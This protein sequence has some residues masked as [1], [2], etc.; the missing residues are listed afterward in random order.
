MTDIHDE[1]IA[2]LGEDNLKI[3]SL[4]TSDEKALLKDLFLQMSEQFNVA[5]TLSDPNGQPVFA[6]CGFTELCGRHIRTT[7][8]GS[9]RCKAE[10]AKRGKIGEETQTPQVYKCHAGIFD[11]TAPILLFGRRIGN[12]SGGQ[13]FTRK[14]D[15]GIRDHLSRY[16]DELGV[17]DK[18]AAMAALDKHHVNS[19]EHLEHVAH[20]YF[21]IG[22]L[23][24]HYFQFQVEHNY[25][26]ESILRVNAELE[27]RVAERTSQLQEKVDELKRTQMQMVQQEKLAGIGQL[28]AGVAHEINNPLGFIMGN[29][30][31]LDQY[32]Q[33]FTEALNEYQKFKSTALS[34]NVEEMLPHAE[35]IDKFLAKRKL[36]MVQEDAGDLLEETGE[37]LA[38]IA[39]IVQN[40]K[41]FSQVDKTQ[42]EVDYDFNEGL[43]TTLLMAQNEY[44]DVVDI[45]EEFGNIPAV[46]G[47][48]SE[49]NQVLLN[50]LLN[51]VQAVKDRYPTVE[52]R[53]VR[54]RTWA[55]SEKVCC[56][57]YDNGVGISE[58]DLKRVFEPFFTTRPPGQGTG[59]GLSVAHDTL[60]KMG[61]SLT[62]ESTVNEGTA[63]HVCIPLD[64]V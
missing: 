60:R 6:Y 12:I 41:V 29:L 44:R 62:I 9:K 5:T 39:D 40:L 32:V 51:A 48:A 24:S 57:I 11:F 22:K 20:I 14:A 28:A 47:N 54:I 38:R 4:I 43:K 59:L 42:E 23:L 3:S 26:K 56:E 30:K 27:D 63:V 46:R 33:K 2:Y 1:L 7:E 49:L 37:G 52:E 25:W 8:E 61:G 13:S 64:T 53:Q 31:M 18:D 35:E 50:L 55:E 36:R 10:A 15:E 34:F 17:A 58:E 19:W 21:N 16:L 45:V